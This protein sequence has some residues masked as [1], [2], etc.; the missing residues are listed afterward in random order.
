MVPILALMAQAWLGP[1]TVPAPGQRVE[2]VDEVYSVPAS[3]W[4]YVEF[5]L[6]QLPVS[7]RGE[8]EAQPG[9]SVRMT[10]MRRHE[11]KRLRE[12]RPHGAM[13]AT[14]VGMKGVLD[15]RVR[16]PGD[17]VVLV[18]NLDG[19]QAAELRLR[20]A[21]EFGGMNGQT[22]SYLAP[23]RKLLVILVSFAVFFGIVTWSARRLLGAIR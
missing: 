9:G 15:F 21:L 16:A 7:V 11:L 8:Y 12:R 20:V 19:G 6:K 4:R 18:E 23:R 2:L 13:V 1:A 17:Y 10:L 5:S 22:V 14:D 3:E